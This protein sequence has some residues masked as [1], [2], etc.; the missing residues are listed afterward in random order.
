MLKLAMGAAC[1]AML[2][3][4]AFAQNET[5]RV[6]GRVLEESGAVLPGAEVTLLAGDGTTRTALTGP[7]GHFLFE[8]V[9]PG[10]SYRLRA[11]LR[12]FLSDEAPDIVVAAGST[13]MVDLSLEVGCVTNESGLVLPDFELFLFAD[14]AVHVRVTGTVVGAVDDH[15]GVRSETLVLGAVRLSNDAPMVGERLV[16]ISGIALDVGKEYL[17]LLEHRH[18]QRFLRVFAPYRRDV[19]SGRIHGKPTEELGI[20]DGVPVARALENLRATYVKYA[21]YRVSGHSRSETTAGIEALRHRTGWFLA[22]LASASHAEWTGSPS[23][24]PVGG[25]SPEALPR[26]GDVIRMTADEDIYIRDF[27]ARGEELRRQS[28][29]T[30]VDRPH[31]SDLTAV[32]LKGGDV[33]RIADVRFE[34]DPHE[35][36]KRVWVRIEPATAQT[37][38]PRP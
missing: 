10:A 15:C 20:R 3:S 28:P 35:D 6:A 8:N 17:L 33:Y 2:T 23:F 26:R 9:A 38:K 34:P 11:E 7:D 25:K 21:R 27:W 5:T 12:G 16:L 19:A 36:T 14:A 22:G 32:R 37:A 1:F 29:A 4:A 31:S 30:E 18:T 13:R 24:E